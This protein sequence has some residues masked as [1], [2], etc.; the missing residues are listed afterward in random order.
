LKA[1]GNFAAEVTDE[2]RDAQ[3][4]LAQMRKQ[5]EE[6]QV[7]LEQNTIVDGLTRLYNRRY[8]E[9]RL[10]EELSRASRNGGETAVLFVKISGLESFTRANGTLKGD[11]VV[12]GTAE[13]IRSS[14]RR[15][16][17]LTRYDTDV[18]ALIL[19]HTGTNVHIV[20]ARLMENRLSFV[21]PFGVIRVNGEKEAS[22]FDAPFVARSDIFRNAHPDEGSGQAANGSAH[23]YAAKQSHHG[24]CGDKWPQPW[25]GQ[26]SDAGQPSERAANDRTR[27]RPRRCA[28]GRLCALFES[29]VF[30][31]LVVWEENRNVRVPKTF[32]FHFSHC[33]LHLF[34]GREDSENCRVCHCYFILIRDC[35]DYT[36]NV[37]SQLHTVLELVQPARASITPTSMRLAGLDRGTDELG[38]Q[39]TLSSQTKHPGLR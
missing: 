28:F 9:T 18:F 22:A 6:Q 19:P 30:R 38:R 25:N 27:G 34:F 16:D 39:E 23:A 11:E 3:L 31:A 37:C 20:G 10:E 7:L 14:V 36:N 13:I 32:T 29:E 1:F 33:G 2:L 8:F 12:T 5:F 4:K 17:I 21:D 35:S 24:T 26:H 15:L